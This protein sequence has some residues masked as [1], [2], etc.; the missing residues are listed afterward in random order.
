MRQRV[1]DFKQLVNCST[2]IW[3]ENWPN[4]GYKEVA[5][6]LLPARESSMSKENL[7]SLNREEVIEIALKIHKDA[8]AVSRKYF[9]ETQH[10]LHI[11]P[12]LFEDFLKCYK[13]LYNEK[14]M[15]LNEMRRR[16][17]TGLQRLQAT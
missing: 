14:R 10:F 16:Y 5:E 2:V 1:R 17:E 13:T 12:H 3:M 7:F 11:T 9:F 15:N 4:E 6:I 8:I